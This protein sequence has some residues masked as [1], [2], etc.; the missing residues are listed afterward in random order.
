MESQWMNRELNYMGLSRH[1]RGASRRNGKTV[2][3]SV[4]NFEIFQIY[5][6][7]LEGTVN[8]SSMQRG[9]KT[10]ITL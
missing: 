6:D 5:K 4:N 10:S 8:T 7:V 2:I 3:S 9:I 1:S